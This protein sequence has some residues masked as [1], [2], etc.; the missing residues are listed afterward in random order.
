MIN[1][2]DLEAA[3]EPLNAF[4][5]F[6]RTARFCEGPLQN[7]TIGVKAN[8]AVAGMPWTGGMQAYR[9][10][11][12]SKDAE[13]VKRLRNAGAA[14]VGTLNME[15]AALGA[16][17]DNPFF[18]AT[19]NPHKIGYTPGGS[20]GGSGA[21]V[22]AG[23]C[24]VALGTDTMGSVRVPAAYCGVYG[25]K[26]SRGAVSQDGLE[27]CEPMLDTIGPLA[28]TLEEL[29]ACSR[30]MM[31]FGS[32]HVIDNI[33]L[34]E[35]LGD[36]DCEPA[37]LDSY[38]NAKGILNAQTIFSLPYPLT[39]VRFAGFILASLAL[40]DSLSGIVKNDPDRLSDHLKHLMTYGPKR[41]TDD[42]AEDR[43]ILEQVKDALVSAVGANGAIL[44]PTT[45]QAAFS[46]GDRAPANQADFTCIA[47]IAG[48]PAI[49]IPAGWDE[50][51]LPVGVQLIG[52][53]GNEAGL[54]ELARKLDGKLDAY[55]RPETFL[56]VS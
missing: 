53:A 34:L 44:L 22:A 54:F 38:E 32:P 26:S 14:I 51:G 43:N 16:K 4:T 28:R 36:V 29:E 45:P 10:R 23:L 11:I 18:G 13:V 2:D 1:W 50:D 15:E 3:N 24:D 39:Q 20:S 8:I 47:S 9:D 55:R 42:L 37:V 31:D 48:L 27:L 41:S 6:D 21:A 19:Q 46:H 49:T 17:T 40:A 30:I 5:D 7:V 56:Q 52:A 25:L 12:A 35:N 33:I